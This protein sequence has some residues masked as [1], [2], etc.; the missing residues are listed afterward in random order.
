MKAGDLTSSE[1][2]R[3]IS[4]IDRDEGERVRKIASVHHG[5]LST[6]IYLLNQTGYHLSAVTPISF[7][8]EVTS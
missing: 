8:E 7:I 4:F 2:M 1:L 5:V 6:V 3:W